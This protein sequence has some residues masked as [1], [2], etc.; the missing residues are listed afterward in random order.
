MYNED[1]NNYGQWQPVDSILQ[2]V[3][4]PIVLAAHRYDIGLWTAASSACNHHNTLEVFLG[5]VQMQCLITASNTEQPNQQCLAS[6]CDIFRQIPDDIG[7]QC[8]L[9]M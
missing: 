1:G 5:M 2:C 4:M 3:K 9:Q 6:K 7:F 8:I